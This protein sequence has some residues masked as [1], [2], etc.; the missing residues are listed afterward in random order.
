MPG[1]RG[2]EGTADRERVQENAAVV[3]RCRCWLLPQCSARPLTADGA[4]ADRHIAHIASPAHRC[5]WLAAHSSTKRAV[6]L[7]DRRI[8]EQP[9]AGGDTRPLCGNAGRTCRRNPG[10]AAL[11]RGCAKKGR[12]EKG[13]VAFGQHGRGD[14][15]T[16][17]RRATGG[18]VGLA[19]HELSRNPLYRRNV[20]QR[21]ASGPVG[22]TAKAGT[23]F[24]SS[25]WSRTSR[26][27]RSGSPAGT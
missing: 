19:A 2:I 17:D 10:V 6:W 3:Q 9:R 13:S 25:S 12:A 7:P 20:G 27:P 14:R 8:R 16:D 5:R 18:V 4:A 23:G 11:A 21:T 1:F 24:A 26:P 22:L 15:K